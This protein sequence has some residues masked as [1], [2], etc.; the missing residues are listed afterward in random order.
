MRCLEVSRLPADRS[1]VREMS[2]DEICQADRREDMVAIQCEYGPA[3][4]AR[5]RPPV[6]QAIQIVDVEQLAHELV[7]RVPREFLA[8]RISRKQQIPIR[9]LIAAGFL[10]NDFGRQTALHR[11][12]EQRPWR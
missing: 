6:D 11:Q 1:G 12:L 2:A 7:P 5:C 9:A 4:P 3:F 10:A 8:Y